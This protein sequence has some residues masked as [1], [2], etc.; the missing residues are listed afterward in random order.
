MNQS[1]QQAEAEKRLF[2]EVP[3]KD[4]KV[5]KFPEGGVRSGGW[6]IEVCR[7]RPTP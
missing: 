7:A 5:Y 2:Q 4:A 1:K 6:L 3:V